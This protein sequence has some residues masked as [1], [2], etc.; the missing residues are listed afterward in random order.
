VLVS[1]AEARQ[2]A[3]VFDDVYT[4]DRDRFGTEPNP[5][6][7][8]DPRVYI[9][10]TSSA[11]MGSGAGGYQDDSSELPKAA[12]THSN[13]HE[14]FVMNTDYLTPG[15]GGYAG[16]LAHEFQH[17]IHGNYDPSDEDWV[18]EGSA[19]YAEDALDFQGDPQGYSAS[20]LGEPDALLNAGVGTVD[21]GYGFL[22]VRYV[23]SRFTPD[24]VRDWLQH[25]EDGLRGLDAALKA[26]GENVTSTDVLEGWVVA[27]LIG[28]NARAPREYQYDR[29]DFSP[30]TPAPLG[31]LPATQQTTVNQHAADYYSLEAARDLQVE[32][33][34]STKVRPIP[35][36]PHSG[37][38]YWWSGRSNKSD[39]T[40]THEVDL[41]GVSTATLRYW[42]WFDIEEG[43]DYGYVVVSTDGGKTW[44][45]LATPA[46][47]NYDPQ[48]RTY[49]E[50]FYTGNSGG[51]WVE[52]KA[53]LTPFARKKILLRFEYITDA[54]VTQSGLAID[55]L[56]IPEINYY[57]DAETDGG[58]QAAGFNR[59][60]AYLPQEWSLQLV[61]VAGG[62]PQVQA[63][64]LTDGT[65]ASFD[66]PAS[67]RAVLI[68]TALAPTT[69]EPATYELSVK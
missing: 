5:G 6:I 65:R 16:T 1:D 29:L 36:S 61:T 27:N 17:M 34:G 14:L 7:D 43:W 20:Y 53:D 57:H 58:W 10:H 8:G 30:V 42:A 33:N 24:F 48:K 37:D 40:L 68:V 35:A 26:A 56:S 39:I 38:H 13:E 12:F 49:T 4:R 63:I 50:R 22:F 18:L 69:I 9:L 46:M 41:S 3:A 66:A 59:V 25:P 23:A 32:F 67:S 45:G 44:Q 21:Y 64:Q 55:D 54:E 31:S 47:T 28:G 62:V 51:A 52:E 19:V 60:T 15:S 11:R 2:A